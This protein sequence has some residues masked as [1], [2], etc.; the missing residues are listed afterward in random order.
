MFKI[1]ENTLSAAKVASSTL[2][3][4]YPTGYSKGKFN[5]GS[6]HKIRAGNTALVAPADFTISF[7]TADF[8]ITFG[9]AIST[10]PAS[11]LLRIELDLGSDSDTL[12]PETLRSKLKPEN[13]AALGELVYVD[14]GSPATAD[15]NGYVETQDLTAL[16][17]FS[18][19][20]TAG[21]AMLA[22]AL[23][24]VPDVPRNVVAAWTSTAILTVTGLDV[25]GDVIVEKSAS[26]TSF[27]G[28][29]AFAE[30]TNIEVSANVTSLTVG[31]GDVL[32]L[33][34]LLKNGNQVVKELENGYQVNAPGR[35]F[36]PFEIEQTE[37][38]AATS[39]ELVCPVAGFISR[40]RG[41]V[42]GAVTTGGDV[43]VEVNTTAVDGLTITIANADAKGTRYSDAPTLRHA[44]AAVAVG[45]RIEIQPA[46]AI[47]TAGQLNGVLEIET[48]GLTG[49]LVVADENAPTATTG[50]VRGTYDPL[51]ACD[52]ATSFGLWMLSI[53]PTRL[54]ADNYDG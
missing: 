8:T 46:S 31:T 7:G 5:Y 48:A 27:T 24:G 54:G 44:T 16:D 17:V 36:L 26:S 19:S 20:V 29:R 23:D 9:T 40:L 11:T 15:A 3:V 25:Y 53:D 1:V 42:Q 35:V 49:T 37:L 52:G 18:S 10:I 21:A 6:A 2:A 45:D 41:I 34:F 28:K 38:L 43:T 39:E 12:R 33:P 30:V 47:D 51:T 32:G 4:G 13:V 14:L 50:D 22:A